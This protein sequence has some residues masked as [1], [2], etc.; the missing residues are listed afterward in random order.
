MVRQV[1]GTE[2][3]RNTRRS[4]GDG[5]LAGRSR[6]ATPFQQGRR[7]RPATTV[8]PHTVFSSERPLTLTV[9]ADN[10]E[11]P[12]GADD[13]VLFADIVRQN[14]VDWTG[15]SYE[16]VWPIAGTVFAYI[17]VDRGDYQGGFTVEVLLDD[18]VTWTVE[19]PEVSAG[20][21]ADPNVP[22]D[23]QLWRDSS[24][25]VWLV[26]MGT[27]GN[28]TTGTVVPRITEDGRLRATADGRLRILENV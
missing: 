23:F 8:I 7:Q 2:G 25:Q 22:L 17:D 9:E 3:L 21:A 26:E 28:F 24:G 12:S 16:I 10:V 18:E 11:I 4:M 5:T 27:D 20:G 15:P 19:V 13:P 14:L 6:I 1:G